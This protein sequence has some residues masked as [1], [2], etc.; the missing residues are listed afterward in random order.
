MD[1]CDHCQEPLDSPDVRCWNCG[2]LKG[3]SR[4]LLAFRVPPLSWL[5]RGPHW[6][7]AVA[8]MALVAGTLALT[9]LQLGD[10]WSDAVYVSVGA[11]LFTPGALRRGLTRQLVLLTLIGGMTPLL[12]GWLIRVFL[13]D[14]MPIA[15][16]M[17]WPVVLVAATG[18]ADWYFARPGDFNSLGWMLLS[19]L[20]AGA[21]GAIPYG[22]LAYTAWFGQWDLGAAVILL[23]VVSWLAV[24]LGHRLSSPTQAR[25]RFW[26]TSLAPLA[27]VAYVLM[28]HSGFFW[29]ARASLRGR[30]P[31]SRSLAVSILELRGRSSDYSFLLA[32]LNEADWSQPTRYP[33][34][35]DGD[36]RTTAVQALIR[37]DSQWAARQ[38][39]ALVVAHPSEAL[40]D[41]TDGLFLEKPSHETV[42]IIMRYALLESI[43]LSEFAIVGQRR[44]KETLTKLRVPQVAYAWILD[45]RYQYILRE[46]IRARD[47]RRRLR[48]LDDEITANKSQ[49]EFL[50]GLLDDD[51]GPSLLDWFDLYEARIDHL[52]TPLSAELHAET[53]RIVVAFQRYHAALVRWRQWSAATKPDKSQHPR[54]PD[55]NIPTTAGLEQ[56]VS[57]YVSE[58]DSKLG[59]PGGNH[60]VSPA[61]DTTRGSRVSPPGPERTLFRGPQRAL[62]TT[63]CGLAGGDH[64]LLWLT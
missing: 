47:E 28:F 4:A 21:G 14:R 40:L 56:E 38:L 17:I 37:H 44:H 20:A 60:Q 43:Q 32:S 48:L 61:E 13:P 16:T 7:I 9:G 31:F 46:L 2:C 22:V 50:A 64:N 26:L 10:L 19:C 30:G 59:Q 55:W 3:E 24:P 62:T 53:S 29:F 58:V 57:R 18:I 36:W 12:V 34:G 41:M 8:V 1:C 54:E 11:A 35:R 25:Q 42:P 33:V 52:L 5:R 15:W 45:V 27:I 51:A 39:G 63:Y 23:A 49:R 6:L